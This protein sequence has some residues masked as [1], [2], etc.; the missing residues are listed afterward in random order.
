MRLTTSL[1]IFTRSGIILSGFITGIVFAVLVNHDLASLSAVYLLILTC[2]FSYVLTFTTIS[3]RSPASWFASLAVLPF[4]AMMVGWLHWNNNTGRIDDLIYEAIPV[5]IFWLFLV[6]PFLQV[7][8]DKKDET[9]SAAIISALWHN[10]FTVASA[11]LFTG[12]FWVILLLWCRLFSLIGIDIFEYLFFKNMYFPPVATGTAFAASIALCRS[13]PAAGEACRRFITLLAGVILPF[14]AAISLLFLAFLPFTGL[15]AIPAHV[16]VAMLLNTMAL[17][18]MVMVA[19]TGSSET[20]TSRYV[21]WVY[22]LVVLAQWLAPAFALLAGYALWLRVA[23]YGW[24]MDRI[25]AAV[26]VMLTLYWTTGCCWLQRRAW[27]QVS[28]SVNTLSVRMLG[29]L[30]L[31]WLLLHTPVIDPYHIMVKSQQARLEQGIQKADFSDIYLFSQAGRRGHQLLLALEAHP[32]WLS[33]PAQLRGTLAQ[34]LIENTPS[35]GT[36]RSA[37]QNTSATD[38]ALFH[39]RIRIRQGSQTPESS[40]WK[41]LTEDNRSLARGCL[42]AAADC[43]VWTMDLNNDGVAEVLLYDRD[44]NKITLFAHQ[45]GEWQTVGAIT[46]RDNADSFEQAV[47]QGQLST[48][49][50]I[51]RDLQIDG[52]RYPVNYYGMN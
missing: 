40:W 35:G 33:D 52:K 1:S 42:N 50:K 46:V 27:R 34:A 49:E 9:R 38:L 25:M 6:M 37:I 17:G 10:S 20:V 32:Q 44:Q 51:W 15:A 2:G 7:L 12:L 41:S 26:M 43:L 31:L 28:S 8:V 47:K 16:S 36:A 13:L 45:S 23:Q 14:H 19:I 4:L 22:K 5:V 18:M 30:A 39:K 29:L 11:M 24:T 48:T 3:F 21:G